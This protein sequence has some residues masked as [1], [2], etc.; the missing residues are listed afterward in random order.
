M[1][2][3]RREEHRRDLGALADGIRDWVRG[4]DSPEAEAAGI[5]IAEAVLRL[6][7]V[8]E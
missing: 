2:R 5:A 4:D 3:S 1:I 8:R 7:M 6:S